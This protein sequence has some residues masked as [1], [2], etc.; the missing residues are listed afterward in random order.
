[1]KEVCGNSVQ[2]NTE[3]MDNGAYFIRIHANDGT[4]LNRTFS[5]AR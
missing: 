3:A 5:V 4:V 2:I 1:M